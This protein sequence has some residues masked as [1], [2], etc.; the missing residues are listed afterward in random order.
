MA[1]FTKYQIF[2]QELGRKSHNLHTDQLAI[3]LSNTA[4]NVATHAVLADVTEISTANGYT[5]S[6]GTL[7]LTGISYAHTAG[8]GKLVATDCVVT[9]S[10]G[11]VGPF[12]YVILYNATATGDMLIGSWD[13]GASLTLQDG[14]SFTTD[15]DATNGILTIT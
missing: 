5:S 12:R 2:V 15:F 10:G 3:A 1:T 7:L 11:T 13:R 4:P 6:A 9:A 8:V 14:E